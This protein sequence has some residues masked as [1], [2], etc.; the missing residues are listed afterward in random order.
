MASHDDDASHCA[1]TRVSG[2]GAAT[3]SI[4]AIVTS[5]E[6]GMAARVAM[7]SAT[8]SL[9]QHGEVYE[10]GFVRAERDFD[11][12]VDRRDFQDSPQGV[13]TELA[14]GK[15]DLVFLGP[16]ASTRSAG[17]IFD[18]NTRYVSTGEAGGSLDGIP[19]VT[20]LHWADEQVGFLAGVAA[21]TTTKTGIVGF[22]GAF[23]GAGQEDTRAGFEA[24][25]HSIDPDI[26]VLAGY[27]ADYGFGSAP[28][29]S[30]RAAHF[31]ANLL[32]DAGADVI[33]HDVGGSGAG[34]LQAASE[35]SANF[36]WVIG[37][38]TDQWLTASTEE[39]P[40]VLTSIVKHFD[41]EIYT[42]IEAYLDDNLDA[43]PRQLTVA[44]DMITYATS[45]DALS[46]DART[47][48]DRTIRQLLAGGI[49]PPRIPTSA[50]TVLEAGKG[51]GWY[52]VAEIPFTFTVPPEWSMY[53][54]G[55]FKGPEQY[56]DGEWEGGTGDPAFGLTFWT[57]DNLYDDG[58][59]QV[60]FDPPVGRTVD[61]LAEAWASMPEFNPTA[62]ID[63]T[64]DGFIG[65]Q[66]EFTVPDYTIGEDC[67]PLC[68]WTWH[69]DA[70]GGGF[71]GASAEGPNEH[72]ILQIL[73]VDGT[74]LVISASYFPDAS[75]QDLADLDEILDS[76]RI[77]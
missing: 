7:V 61:E 25:A 76:I 33:F 41:T 17:L 2:R 53:A 59:R 44:D 67:D 62:A 20:S 71:F 64:V 48:L 55:V 60:L 3:A 4:V 43:G 63:I 8:D 12:T 45:G 47:N 19:N 75:P 72:R 31:V 74:R 1:R 52:E 21:A 37:A 14:A 34:V 26:D 23:N 30:P 54:G 42:L 22:L 16:V 38:D 15:L 13:I 32:Y 11:V 69:D 10:Q 57:I 28:L 49:R 51:T 18:P 65:K 5:G 35:L 24:G 70:S 27:V 46:D 58:C 29:D 73:D 68:L 56:F 66:V 6:T 36:R 39:R 9:D 40:H 77:G 50:V